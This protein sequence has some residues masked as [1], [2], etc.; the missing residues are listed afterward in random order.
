MSRNYT[1]R[2]FLTA[3]T[4][5]LALPLVAACQAP[6]AAPSTPAAT[7]KPAATEPP[8]PAATTAAAAAPAPTQAPA[9]AKPLQRVSCRLCWL[10]NGEFAALLNAAAEGYYQAEGLEMDLRPGGAGIDPLPLVAGKSE[11]F[12]VVAGSGQLIAAVVNGKMPLKFIGT[13]MQKS[14]SGFMYLLKDGE[15]PDKRTPKDWKGAKV[16]V[17]AEGIITVKIIAAMNGLTEKDYEIVVAGT[18]PE[19]LLAGQI[20]YFNGWN[21]NQAWTLQKAGKKWGFI[22]STDYI[23]HYADLL[24]A[25]SDVL[26]ANPDLAKRFVRATMKGLQLGID[27][28]KKTAENIVKLGDKQ[29]LEQNTWRMGVQNT[30]VTSDD[31]RKNGL[32]YMSPD[33]VKKISQIMYDT[34]EGTGADAKRQLSRVPEA[35][36]VMTNDFLPGKA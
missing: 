11:E 20:D 31:T 6:V 9:A 29:D 28:P 4:S 10:K 27:N 7:A 18:G 5:A 33:R 12:G 1:R 22:N 15:Q 26:D 24:F 2:R 25:R 8:K 13:L 36:E 30:M 3:T 32:G 17:Q 14:P 23:P 19:Q 21:T 34:T 35:N 16:G